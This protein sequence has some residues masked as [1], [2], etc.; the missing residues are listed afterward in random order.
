[1]L[2]TPQLE[3]SKDPLKHERKTLN[4]LIAKQIIHTLGSPDDLLQVQVRPLWEDRYRVNV[5]V[6]ADIVSGK[7]AHS[8]FLTADGEG[9]I[10]RSTPKIT[11]HY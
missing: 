6:G 5:F 3:P 4:D 8:Y 9:T 2:T 7:V 10:M 11:R 1:M